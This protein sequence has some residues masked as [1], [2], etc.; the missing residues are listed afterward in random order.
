MIYFLLQPST[1]RKSFQFIKISLSLTTNS[2]FF[3]PC[4]PSRLNIPEI[5][6]QS[7]SNQVFP[8]HTEQKFLP[9]LS[10]DPDGVRKQSAARDLTLTIQIYVSAVEYYNLVREL[11]PA[12]AV[13]GSQGTANSPSS[14][15]SILLWSSAG[16]NRLCNNYN[17]FYL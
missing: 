15:A 11:N 2:F 3:R 9:L 14:T 8:R 16:M 12:I 6:I 4:T 17:L 13:C 7:N 1:S 5:R 10:S